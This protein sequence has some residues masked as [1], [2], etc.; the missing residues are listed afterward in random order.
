M[1]KKGDLVKLI[2]SPFNT[3]IVLD[4]SPGCHLS[5][6]YSQE[7][8]IVVALWNDYESLV[9]KSRL[10]SETIRSISRFINL[11]QTFFA[12]T[13]LHTRS[14]ILE[15]IQKYMFM[16]T[17]PLSSNSFRIPMPTAT[18]SAHKPTGSNSAKL[19]YSTLSPIGIVS[20]LRRG[21]KVIRPIRNLEN[22]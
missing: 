15:I 20:V 18:L 10:M 5:A 9:S 3:G 4:T 2:V 19:Y 21:E 22:K 7:D 17:L 12:E 14:K 16:T 11:D 8:Q 13:N 6:T 1:I